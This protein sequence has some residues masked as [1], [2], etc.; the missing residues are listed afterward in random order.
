MKSGVFR[1][2]IW[3]SLRI[4]ASRTGIPF[5]YSTGFSYFSL[6]RPVILLKTTRA[7][8]QNNSKHGEGHA[9][10]EEAQAGDQAAD[11]EDQ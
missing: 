10:H 3:V 9:D 5:R 4:I 7:N 2:S 8:P 6:V 11:V 1:V